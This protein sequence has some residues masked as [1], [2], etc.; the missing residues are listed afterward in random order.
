MHTQRCFS[1]ATRS[2]PSSSRAPR[3]PMC[4]RRPSRLCLRTFAP[5]STAVF[6]FGTGI[7]YHDEGLLLTHDN[8]T[9]LKE[10][11]VVATRL[12]LSGLTREVKGEDPEKYVLQLVDTLHVTNEVVADKPEAHV[13]TLAKHLPKSVLLTQKEE[14]EDEEDEEDEDDGK[15]AGL[16]ESS[17]NYEASNAG[18]W[19]KR[20]EEILEKNREATSKL[21][22]TDKKTRA[23][24]QDKSFP[25]RIARG[26]VQPNLQKKKHVDPGTIEVDEH[27]N[28]VYFPVNGQTVGVHASLLGQTKQEAMEDCY[29]IAPHLQDHG[30]GVRALRDVPQQGVLQGGGSQG[31]P[32][33][34][35]IPGGPSGSRSCASSPQ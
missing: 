5:T 30:G 14:E 15:Q 16:R 1:H 29:V 22:A 23:D 32:G 20:Q 27:N 19:A 11:M 25:G 35:G 24:N 4:T 8:E 2:T 28:M 7:A 3:S 17:R 21:S 6:G 10:G 12:R 18:Q 13:L 33:G 34:Q 26:Q 31:A 9:V